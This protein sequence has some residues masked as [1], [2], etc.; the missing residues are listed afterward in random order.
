MQVVDQ[1]DYQRIQELVEAT[2]ADFWAPIAA[3][4]LHWFY[5]S[6]QTW[7][8]H[9]SDGRW[10][11]W[12]VSTTPTQSHSK[13]APWTACIDESGAPFVRWFIGGLTNAAFNELDRNVLLLD[14]NT[15][16]FI[17]DPGD[18]TC[19]RMGLREL[20]IES[21]L[22]AGVLMQ[23]HGVSSRKPIALYLPNSLCAV[24][25]IEAA[26]RAGVPFVAIA[27]GTTSHSLA[28][29]LS[30]T[31]SSVIV[32]I[33]DLVL[34]AQDAIQ[35]ITSTPGSALTTPTLVVEGSQSVVVALQQARKRLLCGDDSEPALAL[36][37][38]QLLVSALWQVSPP[39]P[40]DASFPLFI[41][42]TSGSTGRAKGIVHTHGGYE[43]GLCLTT[44]VI[45]SLRPRVCASE[46]LSVC[47]SVFMC[48][49]DCA[50]ACLGQQLTLTKTSSSRL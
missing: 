28:S 9:A 1:E 32:T 44:Q 19:E 27:S 2:P 39:V 23:D 21:V 48:V 43:V 47:A 10:I 3:R 45:A 17:T 6:Q 41:L 50:S 24:V 30:D 37:P 22:A 29:R 11:G 42:Y 36:S 46:R 8:T 31:R 14:H 35:L 12:H 15:T 18:G 34:V 49:C 25:W 4:E 38:S 16:A 33:D 7:L 40:V 13:S 5:A 20:L 26:K